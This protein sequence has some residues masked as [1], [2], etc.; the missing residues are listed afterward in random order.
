M[1]LEW[2][3]VCSPNGDDTYIEERTE[4]LL[5]AGQSGKL[6]IICELLVS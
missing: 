6:Y 3:T 2:D 1:F 4:A 5:S